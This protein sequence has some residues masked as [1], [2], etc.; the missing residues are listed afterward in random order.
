MVLQVSESKTYSRR[1]ANRTKELLSRHINLLRPSAEALHRQTE[2][3]FGSGTPGV[4]YLQ[5]REFAVLPLN[6]ERGPLIVG[7]DEATTCHIIVLLVSFAFLRLI[8]HLSMF[9]GAW[10]S[11]F[12][13]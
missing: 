6:D 11:R 8:V 4:L 3:T 5:Q 1:E 13:T 9:F 7:T 12:E 10:M 2:R